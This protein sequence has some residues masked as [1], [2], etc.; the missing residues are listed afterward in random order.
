MIM[1]RVFVDTDGQ[2]NVF[3]P[4]GELW[5]DVSDLDLLTES[6]IKLATEHMP[7][8]GMKPFTIDT[9]TVDDWRKMIRKMNKNKNGATP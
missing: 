1:E 7:P 2:M 4:K 3:G 5:Y 6:E 9:E 8:T